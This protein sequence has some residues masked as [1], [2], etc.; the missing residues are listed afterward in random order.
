MIDL[1][2]RYF[3]YESLRDVDQSLRAELKEMLTEPNSDPIEQVRTVIYM[4]VQRGYLPAIPFKIAID[5]SRLNIVPEYPADLKLLSDEA[6][7]S[8][9]LGKP[10]ELRPIELITDDAFGLIVQCDKLLRMF[11]PRLSYGVSLG[12]RLSSQLEILS[13]GDIASIGELRLMPTTHAISYPEI[14]NHFVVP[15]PNPVRFSF[16]GVKSR[17]ADKSALEKAKEMADRN[18]N[19]SDILNETGWFKWVDGKWRYEISDDLAEFNEVP[20]YDNSHLIEHVKNTIVI[21]PDSEG[22]LRSTYKWDTDYLINHGFDPR[23]FDDVVRW[24]TNENNLLKYTISLVE[25]YDP[26]K[27]GFYNLKDVK[28]GDRF[29]LEE[30]LKHD[31]LFNAYPHLR[32]I[33]VI[34]KQFENGVMGSASD[35]EINLSNELFQNIHSGDIE[36]ERLAKDELMSVLLHEVQHLI[37]FHELFA[38]GGSPSYES[39]Q[40]IK[41]SIYSNKICKENT[42]HDWLGL[43]QF[44]LAERETLLKHREKLS[45]YS[46]IQR[47]YGYANRDKPSSVWRLIRNEAQWIHHVKLNLDQTKRTQV[48]IPNHGRKGRNEAIKHFAFECA[49]VLREVLGEDDY[50]KFK[51]DGIEPI[52]EI[53]KVDRRINKFSPKMKELY[54]LRSYIKETEYL[55]EDLKFKSNFDIY[56]SLAGEIEARCVQGRIKLTPSERRENLDISEYYVRGIN[57]I[58]INQYDRFIGSGDLCLQERLSKESLLAQLDKIYPLLSLGVSRCLEKGERG[59]ADSIVLLDGDIHSI[60]QRL[61]LIMP[62]VS[63]SVI[64]KMLDVGRLPQGFYD[65][66]KNIIFLVVDNLT[67]SEAVGVLLHEA[68]HS[69]HSHKLDQAAYSLMMDQTFLPEPARSVIE[70]AKQRMV[71]S[72]CEGDYKE[73]APYIVEEALA[74]MQKNGMDRFDSATESKI[75][76]LLG[77]RLGGFICQVINSI[78]LFLVRMGVVTGSHLTINDVL[79]YGVSSAHK[80]V[81]K[82]ALKSKLD[83]CPIVEKQVNRISDS[84]NILGDQDAITSIKIN[85]PKQ[86]KSATQAPMM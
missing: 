79:Y 71:E 82:S 54:R 17:T 66:T 64:D 58:V 3:G 76:G 51:S 34:V 2:N 48:H 23:S 65:P 44:E 5:N 56:Q 72:G 36:K 24:D 62:D 67:P 16:A 11:K 45:L 84:M 1:H 9:E 13:S 78:K 35:Y 61:Q 33:E 57:P 41:Q 22:Y 68:I 69:N 14:N 29:S 10:I 32:S 77:Q 27:K 28:V 7:N 30:I 26:A 60:A 74:E 38:K 55:I 15:Q 4:A 25:F 20:S 39:I 40:F 46:S 43:N 73:A 81:S 8:V 12:H 59:E 83:N 19:F 80:H 86:K 42:L 75:K 21:E 52:K 70:R 47:L 53:A 85:K 49:C 18:Q 6:I 63:Q 31:E 37:Q 50:Q